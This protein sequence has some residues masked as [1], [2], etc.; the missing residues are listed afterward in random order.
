MNIFVG[1]LAF[2]TTEQDLRQLFESVEWEP[3]LQIWRRPW[4][5]EPINYVYIARC[6]NLRRYIGTQWAEGE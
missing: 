5:H 6:R 3:T 2:T 4:Y 1:N